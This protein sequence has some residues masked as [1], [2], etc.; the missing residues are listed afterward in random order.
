MSNILE[1][2]ILIYRP[3]RMI[4]NFSHIVY[5]VIIL[6]L[7]ILVFKDSNDMEDIVSVL[8]WRIHCPSSALLSYGVF[9]CPGWGLSQVWTYILYFL[10]NVK[11]VIAFFPNHTLSTTDLLY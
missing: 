1:D 8:G 11:C 9:L 3:T 5:R 10:L 6:F 2:D 7:F 4:C